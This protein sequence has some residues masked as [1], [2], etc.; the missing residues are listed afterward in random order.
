[1]K[2]REPENK[3]KSGPFSG[4]RSGKADRPGDPEGHEQERKV[5]PCAGRSAYHVDLVKAHAVPHPHPQAS[6]RGPR[7]PHEFIG[8]Q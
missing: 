5:C 1:M 4:G 7:Q 6:T 2:G 8:G 3:A